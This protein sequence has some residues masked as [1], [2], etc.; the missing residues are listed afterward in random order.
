MKIYQVEYFSR[1]DCC[2]GFDFFTNKADAK[3]ALSKFKKKSKDDFDELNSGI[4][5]ENVTPNSKGIIKILRIWA[6]EPQ[7]G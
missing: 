6:S 3:K 5:V 7:N 2:V 4:R 1:Q